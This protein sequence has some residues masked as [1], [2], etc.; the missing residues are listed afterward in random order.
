MSDIKDFPELVKYLGRQKI[1]ENL[2]FSLS[3][4]D[5][6]VEGSP[7][8]ALQP[9]ILNEFYNK[10]EAD[11]LLDREPFGE[12]HGAHVSDMLRNKQIKASNNMIRDLFSKKAKITKHL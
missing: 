2:P 11:R 6:Y 12:L 4:S 9:E 8:H 10:M 3:D 7:T 1:Q 5:A